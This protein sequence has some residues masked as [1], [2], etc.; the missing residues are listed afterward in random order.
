MNEYLWDT[1]DEVADAKDGLKYDV[2]GVGEDRGLA[3]G[4]VLA[5]PVFIRSSSFLCFSIRS[6]VR[7][8]L[9]E[10]VTVNGAYLLKIEIS[11]GLH[12]DLAGAAV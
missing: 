12:C 3:K 2:N 8:T 4:F 1:Q 10:T 6:L 7:A 11:T 9:A 5:F